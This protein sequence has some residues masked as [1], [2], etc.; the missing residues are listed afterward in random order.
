MTF[1]A[2]TGA[3]PGTS[4]ATLTYLSGS[5]SVSYTFDVVVVDREQVAVN[6][7]QDRLLASPPAFLRRTSM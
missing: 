3:T 6:T 2:S 4:T 5:L 7:V 1:A